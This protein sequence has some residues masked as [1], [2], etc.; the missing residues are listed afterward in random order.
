MLVLLTVGCDRN[1]GGAPSDR[2]DGG[3]AR[4]TDPK[5]IGDGGRTGGYALSAYDSMLSRYR[6]DKDIILWCYIEGLEDGVKRRVVEVQPEFAESVVLRAI[7]AEGVRDSASAAA[8]MTRLVAAL[9]TDSTSPLFGV[10]FTVRRAVQGSVTGGDH[11]AHNYMVAVLVRRLP[12]EDRQLEE[13]FVVI[14][15]QAAAGASATGASAPW[16]LLWHERVSGVEEQLA[17]TDPYALFRVRSSGVVAVAFVRES[18]TATQLVVVAPD[19]APDM[20]ADSAGAWRVRWERAI[21][22]CVAMS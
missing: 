16:Q 21:T 2:A 13:Q 8:S 3:P 6:L 7:E 12:Q 11:S 9:P 14:A 22:P 18:A 10:P 17:V 4:T 19:M 5:A 20:A 1:G 15:R